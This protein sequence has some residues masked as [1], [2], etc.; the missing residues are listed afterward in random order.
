MQK[1][2]ETYWNA[3][4]ERDEEIKELRNLLM[5]RDQVI[6]AVAVH[7]QQQQYQAHHEDPGH[8]R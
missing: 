8:S 4:Q 6:H 3:I 7:I 1:Q 2:A 5:Q